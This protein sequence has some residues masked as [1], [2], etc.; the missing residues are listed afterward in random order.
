MWEKKNMQRKMGDLCAIRHI[1]D[2]RRRG[3]VG[4][5]L[6]SAPVSPITEPLPL[7]GWI[8]PPPPQK[9]RPPAASIG[10]QD[11]AV[12]INIIGGSG[13]DCFE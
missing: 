6:K 12:T 2:T 7:L 9:K 5:V 3:A 11:A 8:S 1:G 13:E 4:M 10:P